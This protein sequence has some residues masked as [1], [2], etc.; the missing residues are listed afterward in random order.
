MSNKDQQ[1]HPYDV[2]EE[3]LSKTQKKQVVHD[4]QQLAK[5]ITAMPKNKLKQIDLPSAF[6]DAIIE[7]K[8]ITSHIARK[9]HFQYMAKL[10]LKADHEAIRTQIMQIENLDGHYQIRD[11]VINLWIEQMGVDDKPLFDF[12]YQHFDHEQLGHLR[13]H[14][15]AHMKKPEDSVKRKKLFQALRQ[16]D[17]QTE[18]PNP[19]TLA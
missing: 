8:R 9:R 2:E 16:L 18:L 7:S 1:P 3:V 17:Q 10:L 11:A 14:V 15:R 4:L 13:Q 19:Q 5:E 12:L 6:T